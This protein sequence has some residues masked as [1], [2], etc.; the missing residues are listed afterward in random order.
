MAEPLFDEQVP[1]YELR[2]AHVRYR[3]PAGEVSAVAGVSFD[4][5]ARGV[6]VLAGPSG[7]GKST[8]LRVLGLIDRHTS[9][10]VAWQGRDIGRLTHRARR[11]VRR[12]RIAVVFQAP[13]DNLIGHL[14][15]AGNLTAAAQSAGR[16]AADPAILDWLGIPGTGTWRVSALSGGQQ[17]RLAFGCALAR[18]PAVILADEPTSQLDA[19]SAA[20]VLDVVRRLADRG[21]AVVAASH[22]P[23]LVAIGDRVV[24]LREGHIEEVAA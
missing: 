16:P 8:L 14:T 11:A 18:S 4:V 13:P 20:L 9:G 19:A 2:D 23:D 17:Q 22:D 15:V 3:T 1:L 24:R 21:V 7:S 12:D 10:S 6:T 5:A